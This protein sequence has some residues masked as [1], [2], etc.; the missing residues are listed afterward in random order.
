MTYNIIGIFPT[1]DDA[2]SAANHLIKAGYFKQFR[3]FTN[4]TKFQPESLVEDHFLDQNEI[5]VYT[6]NLNRAYKAKNILVK[7][8]ADI[9]NATWFNIEKIRNRQESQIVPPFKRK[10]VQLQKKSQN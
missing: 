7:F 6:P 1:I 3:G 9:K 8:G 4:N 5:A 2:L 10:K